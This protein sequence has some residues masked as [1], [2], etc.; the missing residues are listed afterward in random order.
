MADNNK[1][2][3]NSVFGLWN[4]IKKNALGIS[5]Q[6]QAFD[7]FYISFLAA[8]QP[9][10]K[11]D[12]LHPW[13]IG[14]VDI[15]PVEPVP[16][17]V[18]VDMNSKASLRN[19]CEFVDK[20]LQFKGD[21]LCE[22]VSSHISS[23]YRLIID[24][25]SAKP[26]EIAIPPELQKQLDA[27]HKLL[28]TPNEDDPTVFD[29]SATKRQYEKYQKLWQAAVIAYSTAYNAAMKDPVARNSWPDVGGTYF[30][31]VTDAINDWEEYGRRSDVE[32][33]EN[34]IASQGKDAAVEFIASSKK[35]I[36]PV[37]G[38]YSK[39]V[40]GGA[41]VLYT[42]IFPSNWC[43]PNADGWTSYHFDSSE[44]HQDY[45]EDSTSYGGGAGIN[46]GFWSASANA[47]HSEA[48]QKH[49]LS[50]D[51][52]KISFEYA[53]V[54]VNRPWMDTLFFRLNNWYLPGQK[55]NAISD[56]SESQLSK[57]IKDVNNEWWLPTVT[58]KLI[59]V[60][61]LVICNEHFM[62]A[63]QASQESTKAG[64]S[65]GWGPFSISGNYGKDSS[66]LVKDDDGQAVGL[67]VKGVQLIGFISE[68]I[69]SSP[70]IDSPDNIIK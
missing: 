44:T 5:D 37:T 42:E 12:F 50:S 9:V 51:S 56:S 58:S 55:A 69:P 52:L 68:I 34:L 19:V 64:G 14:S 60:R 63:Y 38:V 10:N 20:R 36:D 28:R 40:G 16:G 70:K 47:Q 65:F 43:D 7:G 24:S 49:E 21:S 29:K 62:E 61:N 67:G 6:T 25:A 31:S 39:D 48:T 15:A 18:P 54:D 45:S 2:D 26:L 1:I 41:K 33:A 13:K 3:K 35:M 66:K 23:A 11:D 30:Q 8:G 46:L 53:I 57:I 22:T 27:A 17:V 59:L 4:E 32:A